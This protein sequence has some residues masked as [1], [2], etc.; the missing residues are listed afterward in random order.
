[1]P[2][3][4]EPYD[5][6]YFE[7]EGSRPEGYPNYPDLLSRHDLAVV[8]ADDIELHTGSVSGKRILDVGCA[9]GFLT[10]ELSIRGADVTGIDLSSYCI[11]EAI[12][13]FP[14][15]DLVEEDFIT[16]SFSNNEFDLTAGLGVLE[17]MD[18]DLL[19]Q[20]FLNQVNRVTKPT[21]IFYFLFD[22][23]NNPPFYYQNKTTAEWLAAMQAGLPGPYTFDVE[24][25]GHLSVY[26]ATRV[27]VT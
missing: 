9:Y 25:V 24:D 5:V 12:S 7:G 17:C 22:Y 6:S 2:Y 19:M 27:V 11:S 16:N 26:Y 14:A 21:G 15:L 4:G 1:M 8:W 3:L 18:T 20:V 10:E 13:R 23:D